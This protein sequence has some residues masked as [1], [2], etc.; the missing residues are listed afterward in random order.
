MVLN[1]YVVVDASLA[2]KWLVE[3]VDSD[4]ADT[5]AEMWDT[6]GIQTVAPYFLSAEVT[7]ILLQRIKRR[8]IDVEEGLGLIDKLLATGI[9]LHHSQRFIVVRWSWRTSWGREPSTIATIWRWRSFWI[10]RCGLRM[11]GFFDLLVPVTPG[12]DC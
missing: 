11:S 4:K 9:E 2:F 10:A 12:C 3:E 6:T 8:E 7:N 1:D 5:L